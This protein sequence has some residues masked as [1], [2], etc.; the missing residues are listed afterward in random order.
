MS[1]YVHV[2]TGKVIQISRDPFARGDVVRE[3]VL[4]K[5][6]EGCH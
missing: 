6:G 5:E 3:T 4:P 1:K 2:G